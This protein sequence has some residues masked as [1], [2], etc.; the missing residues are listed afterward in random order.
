MRYTIEHDLGQTRAKEVALA[1]W[2]SYCKR[3]ENYRPSLEWRE[4]QVAQIGF[5][6]KGIRIEATIRINPKSIEVELSVP[7][8]LRPFTKRAISVVEREIGDWI[9]KAK[10]GSI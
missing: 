9:A 1:A 6:A 2:D 4:D 5:S 10:Q 7:L 8:L 3:F